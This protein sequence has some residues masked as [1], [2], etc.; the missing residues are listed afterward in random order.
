MQAY[1]YWDQSLSGRD[2]LYFRIVTGQRPEATFRASDGEILE[3]GALA[4]F[5]P[6][7]G[8]HLFPFF[9]IT[10]ETIFD[11]RPIFIRSNSGAAVITIVNNQVRVLFESSPGSSSGT[12]LDGFDIAIPDLRSDYS[13]RRLYPQIN[14]Q[15][16]DINLERRIRILSLLKL[17]IGQIFDPEITKL[18]RLKVPLV[19][20][21]DIENMI[22][23]N[24]VLNYIRLGQSFFL[25]TNDQG[26]NLLALLY[27]DPQSNTIHPPRN[28]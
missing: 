2:Q 6:M 16:C 10:P 15:S 24:R 5:I 18:A 9:R 27:Y 25:F 3:G 4:P 22:R 12:L 11:C 20:F 1:Y 28:Q 8:A 13:N 17:P 7:G 23:E 19:G 14:I 21:P 26:E